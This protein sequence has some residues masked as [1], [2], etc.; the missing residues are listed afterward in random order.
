MSLKISHF[1]HCE[2]IPLN[3]LFC[4]SF[5][6]A[7]SFSFHLEAN[8]D[9]PIF[10]INVVYP[11][12]IICS[13]CFPHVIMSAHQATNAINGTNGTTTVNGSTTKDA[14]TVNGAKEKKPN[15][16]RR[17]IRRPKKTNPK[18]AGTIVATPAE[19]NEATAKLFA[20]LEERYVIVYILR[21]KMRRTHIFLGMRIVFALKGLKQIDH[22]YHA[23]SRHNEHFI[24]GPF[25]EPQPLHTHLT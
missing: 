10:F 9:T 17:I 15:I 6:P 12:D 8:I 16:F 13:N 3:F 20:R 18:V 1:V 14:K 19:I 4:P 25:R 22:S 23:N 21:Y 7:F 24:N 2:F 11:F 5:Q